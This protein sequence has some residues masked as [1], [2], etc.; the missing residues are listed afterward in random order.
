MQNIGYT[1]DVIIKN[2]DIWLLYEKW[3]EQTFRTNVDVL[4]M[5]VF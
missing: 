2:M 3:K 5:Y 4:E 1:S